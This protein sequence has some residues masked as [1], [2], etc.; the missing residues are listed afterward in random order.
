M[1]KKKIIISASVF[2]MIVVVGVSTF[3]G[4]KFL[5]QPETYKKNSETQ[6]VENKKEESKENQT[7][8]SETKE[9]ETLE[10]TPSKDVESKPQPSEPSTNHSQN[11]PPKVED[12]KQNT[13]KPIVPPV[14]NKEPEKET[15]P[16]P[17]CT[18][19]KFTWNWVRADFTSFEECTQMGDRYKEKGYG[20]FCDYYQDDCWTTYYMLTLYERDTGTKYD[21]H[22][23]PLK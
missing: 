6:Q 15:T 18:P 8:I 7:S 3:I 11:V 20:Y 2:F 13:T 19:K 21:Y 22:T 12:N 23:I 4:F 10:E 16:T 5:K 1:K 17:S 14:E 9:N